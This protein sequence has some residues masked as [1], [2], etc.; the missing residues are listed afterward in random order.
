VSHHPEA[1]DAAARP[2]AAASLPDDALREINRLWTIVRALSNTAHDVNNALQVIA[3]S[4]EL[5]ESRELD[6]VV[7]RRIEAIRAESSRAA[8]VIDRLVAYLRAPASTASA[9]DLWPLV[10][11]AVAMRN[12]SAKRRRIALVA[13]R[14]EGAACRA[15]ADGAR[16]LQALLDLL[17]EAEESLADRT[18][19][20]IRVQVE[21]RGDLVD[22]TI[23]ATGDM[24]APSSPPAAGGAPPS[25]AM[26]DS[27][28]VAVTTGAQLWTARSLAMAQGGSVSVERIE[29]G[30]T[31]FVL[32]LP[33]AP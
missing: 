28:V 3:G 5:L 7:G 11:A 2:V 18:G 13:E 31:I 4:A 22:V 1:P 10:D 24:A 15:I 8:A 29:K 30:R 9:L 27:A 26:A 25:E 33:A 20:S 32:R 12:A 19:A 17:L 23:T 14:A 6:P 16:T 21:R